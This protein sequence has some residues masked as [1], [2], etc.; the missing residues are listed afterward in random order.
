[1]KT[2]FL[3]KDFL[4]IIEKFN[5]N[6]RSKRAVLIYVVIFNLLFLIL[7]IYKTIFCHLWGCLLKKAIEYVNNFYKWKLFPGRCDGPPLCGQLHILLTFTNNLKLDSTISLVLGFPQVQKSNS[8]F[9]QS[10]GKLNLKFRFNILY[11]K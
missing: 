7:L 6:Q 2:I 10:R 1:M 3:E 5:E 4:S 9:L 8:Y 11:S